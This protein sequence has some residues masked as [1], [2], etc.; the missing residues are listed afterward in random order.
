M[1]NTLA[2]LPIRNALAV[3]YGDVGSGFPKMN[4]PIP[5]PQ[6]PDYGLRND[7]TK[8]GRGFLG[9][10]KRPDGDVSTE[11]SVGVNIGGREM[12]IPTLVP[13]LSQDEVQYLLSGQR[14]TEAIVRKAVDHAKQRMSSG[15]PVF[16]E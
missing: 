1:N 4:T 12:E 7:G 9:E 6:A 5:M 3:S 13:T 8:K 11:I 15:L 2:Q 16:S 10:L 14:P